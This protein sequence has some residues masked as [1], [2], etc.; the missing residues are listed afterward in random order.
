MIPEILLEMGLG[1]VLLL[2]QYAIVDENIGQSFDLMS[3]DL[4]P[5]LDLPHV[6]LRKQQPPVLLYFLFI[7]HLLQQPHVHYLAPQEK[8][9]L[10]EISE[11][12]VL[13]TGYFCGD[14]EAF[15][16]VERYAVYNIEQFLTVAV[17][18][19]RRQDEHLADPMPL[20][21]RRQPKDIFRQHPH[22]VFP[23]FSLQFFEDDVVEPGIER[24]EHKR[25][26]V[27]VE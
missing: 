14:F 24:L 3:R 6:L 21:Q 15:G 11:T 5:R 13:K 23:G 1:E 4:Q 9:Q 7:H 27:D 8:L 22:H 12:L 10:F 18:L 2:L 16:V 26:P 17:F 19:V 20:L 25:H